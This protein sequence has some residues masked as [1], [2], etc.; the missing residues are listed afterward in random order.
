MIRQQI[1]C[2]SGFPVPL[3]PLAVSGPIPSSGGHLEQ[4]LRGHILASHCGDDQALDR[5]K[6]QTYDS[7]IWE[8]GH[9]LCL[10]LSLLFEF[11]TVGLLI[12]LHL[13]WQGSLC[14]SERRFL[15]SHVAWIQSERNR[16]GSPFCILKW[17]NHIEVE[18]GERNRRNKNSRIFKYPPPLSSSCPPLFLGVQ[19]CN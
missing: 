18:G 14:H 5:C 9:Q 15:D 10:W 12:H 4:Q 17:K 7:L 2:S 11:L 3:L 19:L 16:D 13:V 1:L 8:A 6:A